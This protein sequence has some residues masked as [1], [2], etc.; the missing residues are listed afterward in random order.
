MLNI[1]SITILDCGINISGEQGS[2]QVEIKDGI[3]TFDGKQ[4]TLYE[5]SN[6]VKNNN[7]NEICGHRV[8]QELAYRELEELD[9][10]V[11]L[12]IKEYYER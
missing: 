4:G 2:K 12:E 10:N 9:R 6:L 1:K 5:R 11:K 8:A 3:A 7:L